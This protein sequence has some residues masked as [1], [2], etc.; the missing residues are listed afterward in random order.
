MRPIPKDIRAI[1]RALL[2]VALAGFRLAL[3]Q[4]DLP[5]AAQADL[6]RDQIY[7]QAKANDPEGVLHSID[8][9]KKLPV[10]FPP[11]LLWLEAMAAH[12]AGDSGRAVTALT[13]FIARAERG[14][15]QYREALALYPAYKK[16]AD[17]AAALQVDARRQALLQ[18][19]PVILAEVQANT[20]RF[21]AGGFDVKDLHLHYGWDQTYIYGHVNAKPFAMT[22]KPVSHLLWD[23]YCAEVGCDS[24]DEWLGRSSARNFKSLK[25]AQ[26]LATWVG[27]R[28]H[29]AWRLPTEDELLY[30]EWSEFRFER[31]YGKEGTSFDLFGDEPTPFLV[32]DCWDP[33]PAESVSGSGANRYFN[34]TSRCDPS[35]YLIL[36]PKVSSPKLAGGFASAQRWRGVNGDYDGTEPRDMERGSFDVLLVQD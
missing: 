13:G 32:R 25:E 27:L 4:S 34:R 24:K 30:A 16:A 14:S 15:D 22:T 2:L 8:A 20:V 21:K 17:A 19:V 6:L 9:Y 3:A 23:V 29:S 1:T 5:P 7:A 12:D 11:P 35:A 33:G 18:R 36:T 26:D 28:L 10:A 31:S